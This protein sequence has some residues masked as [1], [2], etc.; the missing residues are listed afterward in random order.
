[1]IAPTQPSVLFS[2]GVAELGVEEI[3]EALEHLEAAHERRP[4][5]LAVMFFIAF[6]RSRRL[7]H[8]LKI[9]AHDYNSLSQAD[10]ACDDFLSAPP[11][12]TFG[13]E[14]EVIQAQREAMS[15][16]RQTVSR[17]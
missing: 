16:L 13:E 15:Q 11:D 2:L 1:M 17:P 7:N 8:N 14:R 3:E 5:N 6:A 9:L 12:P 4:Q 10:R